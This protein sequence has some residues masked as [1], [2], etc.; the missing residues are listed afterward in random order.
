MNL[1]VCSIYLVFVYPQ[2]KNTEEDAK[3]TSIDFTLVVNLFRI[4]SPW[5]VKTVVKYSQ[6]N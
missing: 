1:A 2:N 5:L 6:V 4:T 3:M